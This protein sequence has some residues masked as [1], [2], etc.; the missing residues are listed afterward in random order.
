MEVIMKKFLAVLF[1]LSSLFLSKNVEAAMQPGMI[2][3]VSTQIKTD[4]QFMTIEQLTNLCC[5]LYTINANALKGGHPEVVDTQELTDAFPR[6]SVGTMPVQNFTQLIEDCK[7]I[8]D[9][10]KNLDAIEKRYVH[11]KLWNYLEK[12]AYYMP[13]ILGWALCFY[14]GQGQILQDTQNV[15][16]YVKDFI[17]ACMK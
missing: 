2:T 4:A 14:Y 8:L 9:K 17:F 10:K 15:Y 5:C 16:G 6:I 11:I 1:F 12:P 3:Q 13:L 7:G